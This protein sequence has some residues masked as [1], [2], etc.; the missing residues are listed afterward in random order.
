MRLTIS[1]D[2]KTGNIKMGLREGAQAC[3]YIIIYKIVCYLSIATHFIY[4]RFDYCCYVTDNF[5]YLVTAVE[6]GFQRTNYSVSEQPRLRD[7][8]ICVTI[9]NGTLERGIEITF[10]ITDVTAES[11]ILL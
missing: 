1:I 9:N 5:L 3:I 7:V 10:N 8:Y 4:M 6:F 11:T 2:F